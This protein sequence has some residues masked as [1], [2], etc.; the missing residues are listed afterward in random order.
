[1]S[2]DVQLVKDL[3][4]AIPEFEEMYST[5]LENEHEVLSHVFFW[6]VTQETVGSYLGTE[7]DLPDWRKTLQFLE[8]QSALGIPEVDTVIVTSF[9][10]NL[11]FPGT[12]GHEIVKHLG[13]IMAA[14]FSRLRPAG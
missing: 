5:H 8:E 6:D 10:Y 14:K 11:P 9:L 3:V 13:P 7:A 12:P 1:M 2:R 4:A